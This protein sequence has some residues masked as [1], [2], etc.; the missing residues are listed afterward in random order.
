MKRTVTAIAIIL[1]LG[2]ALFA[3]AGS[4]IAGKWDCISVSNETGTKVAWT[5]NVKEDAGKLSGS[6]TLVDSGAEIP[7]LEPTLEGNTFSF[8]IR[9][10][11]Q[12]VVELTATIAGKQLDGKFKGH[13]SGTGT[14]KGTRQD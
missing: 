10:N 13:D 3:A 7:A 9:I 5:L 11:E 8:K 4:P 12:E 2:F 14:F 1:F 6:I